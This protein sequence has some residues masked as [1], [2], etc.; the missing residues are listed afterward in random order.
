MSQYEPTKTSVTDASAVH[1]NHGGVLAR[2]LT[3]GTPAARTPDRCVNTPSTPSRRAGAS[4][5]ASSTVHALIGRP[6]RVP[7]L[8]RSP[9]CTS[10]CCGWNTL[11]P[12]QLPTQPCAAAAAARRGTGTRARRPAGGGGT[13]S[14]RTDRTTTR[15]PDRR[16]RSCSITFAV[17]ATSAPMR[18]GLRRLDLDVDLEIAER[19]EHLGERR[20]RLAA[21]AQRRALGGR[22]RPPSR[23]G[24]PTSRSSVAIVEHD[25]V[26]VAIEADVELDAVGAGARAR[27][28]TR[29]IVFSGAC[30]ESPRCA[31]TRGRPFVRRQRVARPSRPRCGTRRASAASLAACRRPIATRR[32]SCAARAPGCRRA[33][34]RTTAS[35]AAATR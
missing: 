7:R 16:A 15:A 20:D 3:L 29:A 24:R 28:R 33:G 6:A 31:H 8:H 13:G 4:S 27:A 11:A 5:A 14:A 32:T 21:D 12:I 9:R 30:A 23:P 17:A 34:D 26:A 35:R 10:V 25:D 22:Q 1:A 2:S 19:V 18:P